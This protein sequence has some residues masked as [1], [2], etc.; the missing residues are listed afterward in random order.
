MNKCSV[1]QTLRN[2]RLLTTFL[3][4]FLG[5]SKIYIN[6]IKLKI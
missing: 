4:I 5:I 3:V 6:N 2:F 1:I